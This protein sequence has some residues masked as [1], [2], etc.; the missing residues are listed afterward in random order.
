MNMQKN[1]YLTPYI[2]EDLM[3]K[4]VFVGGPRQ[5]G[6]TTLC[7]NFVARSFTLGII[8]MNLFNSFRRHVPAT[9]LKRACFYCLPALM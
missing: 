1:R 5:V 8:R 4:M 3:E 2:V 7:R 6:K 9:T